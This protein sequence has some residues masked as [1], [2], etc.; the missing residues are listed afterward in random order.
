MNELSA[1]PPP[2]QSRAWEAL[3]RLALSSGLALVLVFMV[4]VLVS[5]EP[6]KA[7]GAFSLG[8]LNSA[9]ALATLLEAAAPLMLSATGALVAFKAGHFTL[10]GEG[11]VYAG[12]FMAALAGAWC[13]EG[14]F[15]LLAAVMAG[16]LGGTLV[17]APAAAGKR[18]A[19][20]DV[21]LV[22]FLLSQA[23]LHVVDWAISGP[24]RDA[25]NNL[26]A[27]D[28][29]PQASLLPRL[30]HNLPLTP[31]PLVAGLVSVGVWI[32]LS[33]TRCGTMLALYGRNSRFA[34]LQN[35]PVRSFEW[36]P[37]I[38]AGA[39]HGLAGAALSLGSNGTAVRGISGGL[40][41][42]AIGAALVAGG[43]PLAVVPA[44][45][46]FSWLDSGARQAAIFTEL[47]PDAAM[48][49]KALVIMAAT[50]KP[51]YTR[52]KALLGGR[53]RT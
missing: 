35:F 2:P 8:P 24:F 5:D 19:G 38:F 39:M 1:L 6:L 34:A 52:L 23:A 10:G 48:I 47:P 27:M 28:P 36:A 44:A 9:R 18:W 20:A 12:A 49:I 42:N 3:R 25:G 14:S 11:Q 17:A 31:V 4:S 21:L 13:P 51:A 45:V 26:I 40:G 37:I 50:A 53:K 22:T 33:R 32:F 16:V 30:V 43:E 7:F 46:L 41:W 15:G 29:I